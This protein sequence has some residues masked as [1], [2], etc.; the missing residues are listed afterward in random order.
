[1]QEFSSAF[2]EDLKNRYTEL[3][4]ENTAAYQVHQESLEEIFK[5]LTDQDVVSKPKTKAKSKAKA[6]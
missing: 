2:N 1:M 3:N 6:A 5:P 4:E